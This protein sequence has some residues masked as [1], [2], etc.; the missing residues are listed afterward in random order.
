MKL[1]LTL[2]A[3]VLLGVG[4]TACGSAGKSTGSAAHASSDATPTETTPSTIPSSTTS[5]PPETKVDA[6]KDNDVGA[7][8]HDD[9]NNNS[10]LDF[11]KAA[12]PSEQRTITMLVKRYYAAALAENGAA[13]CSMIYSTLVEA[14]PEDYGQSPPGPPYMRGTTCPA[15]MTLLFKHYHDQLALEVPRLQVARV[16]LK[17]HHG[18]AILSFGKRLAERQINV[19]REGHV[20]KL[21]A[22]IDSELS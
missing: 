5:A 20:W 18:L 6:D 13:A 9:T 8:P 14:I 22:L 2:S 7:A 10:T 4:T 19:A 12:S 21:E 16:R 11:G 1:L 15:V 17:E 3:I